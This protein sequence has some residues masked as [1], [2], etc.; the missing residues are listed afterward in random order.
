[1]ELPYLEYKEGHPLPV[2]EKYDTV[3]LLTV[4]HHSSDP[5]ELLRMAWEV[6]N[7]TLIIIESVVGIHQVPPNI[8]YELADLSD[9]HQIA[10]AA[11]ID[12]FYNRVLHDNVPV[13]YNFTTPDNWQAIFRKYNMR[14][15]HTVHEGQ[16]IEIGPE[17]HI[18]FVLE[19]QE[20][21][22]EPAIPSISRTTTSASD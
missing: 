4:L 20:S 10:Y 6:T 5:V 21:G 11:F 12:W 14:L 7:K 15:T 19:K 8:R 9:K 13:P 18:L 3:L 22:T 16:D 17:Y 2:K 1:L